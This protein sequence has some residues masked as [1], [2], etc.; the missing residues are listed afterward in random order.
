VART[1]T[2]DLAARARAFDV[3]VFERAAEEVVRL[4]GGK[5]LRTPS[6]ARVPHLNSLWLDADADADSAEA[7]AAQ[8]AAEWVIAG[9][10]AQGERLAGELP[11]RGWGLER[12]ALLG[13]DGAEPPPAAEALAEEVPYG[14]VRGLRDEWIRSESWASSEEIVAEA[15]ESDRRLLGG[16]P[17]RAFA[18]FEQGRPLAYALL[19]DGGRD[20]ML[21]DVYTTP[22]ARG[23]GI[24]TGVIAAVLHAARAERHEAVFVPTT[25]DGPAQQLYERLGFAPLAVLHRFMREAG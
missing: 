25:A 16:T 4:D 1:T 19:I 24:A 15:H 3:G 21:E 17:T 8:H 9:D 12:V 18:H 10:E 13:R 7:L 22:A 5:L 6:L 11:A 20:G 2:T 14:H 23:R